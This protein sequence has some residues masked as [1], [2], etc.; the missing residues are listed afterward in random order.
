MNQSCA[1][2]KDDINMVPTVLCFKKA[3]GTRGSGQG[4]GDL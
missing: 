2:N 4:E 1:V 3:M